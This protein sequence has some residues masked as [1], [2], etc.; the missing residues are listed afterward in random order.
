MSI[1]D[2][3]SRCTVKTKSKDGRTTIS[4]KLGFWSV[5]AYESINAMCEAMHYFKQYKEDGE[6]SSIIG[7]DDSITKLK[8]WISNGNL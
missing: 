6:Y 8:E 7:G 1:L 4:C 5:E 3:F 2:E